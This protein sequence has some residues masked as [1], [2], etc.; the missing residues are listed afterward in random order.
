MQLSEN[1]CRTRNVI[2][3]RNVIKCYIS[4]FC[5]ISCR[6]VCD[7]KCNKIRR[8]YNNFFYICV[9]RIGLVFDYFDEY[10]T[11]ENTYFLKLDC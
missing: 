8:E 1:G 3:V 7:E 6:N 10:I 2:K 9:H 11:Q 4:H 5:Y